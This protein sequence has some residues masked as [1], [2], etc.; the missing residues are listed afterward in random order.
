MKWL[1]M[2]VYLPWGRGAWQLQD[3]Q[4]ARII[5]VFFSGMI[6]REASMSPRSP[7]A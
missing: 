1:M 6:R 3:P 4:S 2:G 7:F 5:S